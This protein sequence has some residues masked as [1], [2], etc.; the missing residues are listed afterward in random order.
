MK[1]ILQF[2]SFLVWWAVCSALLRF[3]FPHLPLGIILAGG[4]P[5]PALGAMTLQAAQGL[6]TWDSGFWSSTTPAGNFVLTVAQML[7]GST[8]YL[9]LVAGIGG[10]FNMTTPTASALVQQFTSAY[11]HPPAVG[12]TF[13]FEVSNQTGF[14]AT[15]VAG[16]GVTI[17]GTATVA[18]VTNRV[19]LCT[20]TNLGAGP[21]FTGATVSVQ[22]IAGRSN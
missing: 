7:S 13:T 10:V 1:K 9:T 18:T 21:G 4:L 11:G 2:A 5:L 19:W 22:N 3:L 16:T 12:S 14:T 6:A 8:T 15:L 17:N 20:F